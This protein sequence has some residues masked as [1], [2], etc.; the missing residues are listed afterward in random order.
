MMRRTVGEFDDGEKF[1]HLDNWNVKD[2]R[3]KVL[4]RSWTGY[5]EI[6]TDTEEQKQVVCVQYNL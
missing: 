3:H 5:T 4:Y 2:M 1:E 6:Y